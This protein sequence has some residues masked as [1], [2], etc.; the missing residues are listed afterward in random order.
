MQVSA[1]LD[2]SAGGGAAVV[3]AQGLLL[4]RLHT[5]S[6]AILTG[7]PSDLDVLGCNLTAKF[8][9]DGWRFFAWISMFLLPSAYYF[10]TLCIKVILIID[11]KCAQSKTYILPS[12]SW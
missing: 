6:I 12:F 2:P 9:S 3:G 4:W 5:S 8:S 7:F 1:S 11:R 10:M